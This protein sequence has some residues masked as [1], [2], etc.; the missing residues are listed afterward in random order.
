MTNDCFACTYC[1]NIHNDA[2][3]GRCPAACYRNGVSP[4]QLAN[5]NNN[6]NDDNDDDASANPYTFVVISILG[7]LSLMCGGAMA[8]AA[9]S[10]KRANER[11]AA[12]DDGNRDA[13]AEVPPMYRELNTDIDAVPNPQYD[14]DAMPEPRARALSVGNIL[15]SEVGASA[16]V[17]PTGSEGNN[18]YMDVAPTGHSG[19]NPFTALGDCDEQPPGY[20]VLEIGSSTA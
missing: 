20:D 5:N 12:N 14:N 1:V 6:N 11:R 2:I 16:H 4:A 8:I 18:V 7:G 17:A 15:P 3:D 10:R 13:A 19:R 9:A